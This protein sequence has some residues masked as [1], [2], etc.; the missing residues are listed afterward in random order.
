M[1]RHRHHLGHSSSDRYRQQLESVLR[2]L[3][4]IHCLKWRTKTDVVLRVEEAVEQAIGEW[5]EFVK[6]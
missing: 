5:F 4:L 1:R 3:H 2:C 6:G